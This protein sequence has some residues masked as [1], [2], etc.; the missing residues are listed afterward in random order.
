MHTSVAKITPPNADARVVQ[1]RFVV[2]Q[3]AV[4]HVHRA[5]ETL[6]LGCLYHVMPPL[7]DPERFYI[8]S[9]R[10]LSGLLGAHIFSIILSGT[11]E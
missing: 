10:I 11:A 7:L 4:A 3:A 5:I 1:N 8:Q 2:E 9:C 6:L